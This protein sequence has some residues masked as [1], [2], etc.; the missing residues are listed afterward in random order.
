MIV[1]LMG[2]SNHFDQFFLHAGCKL[3]NHNVPEN[4]L[5]AQ[6]PG[7]INPEKVLISFRLTIIATEGR[8]FIYMVVI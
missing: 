6:C 7:K 8:Q 5:H 4:I 2:Q 1:S 3:A